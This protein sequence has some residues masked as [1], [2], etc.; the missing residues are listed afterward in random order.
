MV[1]V[2]ALTFVGTRALEWRETPDARVGGPS[3]AVVRPLAGATC[4]LD[5]LIVAGRSPFPPPFVI[6]H[7]GVAEVV[8]VGDE[9]RAV[10]PGDRVMVPF[11]I[12]CGDCAACRELRTGNCTAVPPASTYGFGFGAE[13]T[14]WG[15]FL[16]DLI[17]VPFADAM[18][19]PLPD[20]ISPEVA[21]SAS[22]NITD[23]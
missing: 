20:G 14:Q 23:G 12:N 6:G 10:A 7:E 15:G 4:D 5:E 22:D 3:E 8:D 2:R 9:V 19:I 18:L 1:A 21:A 13:G 11:Q 16:A 17:A